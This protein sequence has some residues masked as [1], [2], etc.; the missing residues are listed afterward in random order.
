MSVIYVLLPVAALLA[1][2][3]VTAFIV[4]V[5]RGQFDDLDTPAVRILHDDEDDVQDMTDPPANR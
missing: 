2:A 4:A 5:R 1:A 3:A